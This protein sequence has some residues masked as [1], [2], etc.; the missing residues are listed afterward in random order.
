[1]IH[2]PFRIQGK[3][4]DKMEGSTRLETRKKKEGIYVTRSESLQ[5]YVLETWSKYFPV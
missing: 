1:M 2:P 3:H 5:T 4:G